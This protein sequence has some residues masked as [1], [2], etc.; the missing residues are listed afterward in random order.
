MAVHARTVKAHHTFRSVS[1]DLRYRILYL[2]KAQIMYLSMARTRLRTRQWW[3]QFSRF[4]FQGRD[5][6][7]Q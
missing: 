3:N 7:C 5:G 2:T 1:W 6:D 4:I